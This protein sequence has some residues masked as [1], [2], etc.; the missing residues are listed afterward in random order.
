METYEAVEFPRGNLVVRITDGDRLGAV[1]VDSCESMEVACR[2]AERL[3]VE[4]W[5]ASKPA[6]VP[7]MVWRDDWE[8][9][10]IAILDKPEAA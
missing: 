1:V 6:G 3:N 8:A 9:R 5:L 2:Q 10:L 7:S 4:V